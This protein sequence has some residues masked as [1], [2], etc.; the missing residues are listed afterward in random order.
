VAISPVV[1]ATSITPSG[2]P[3][4]SGTSGGSVAVAYPAVSAGQVLLLCA[5]NGAPAANSTPGGWTL[6]DHVD[7]ASGDTAAALYWKLAVGNESG[8]VTVTHTAGSPTD[9]PIGAIVAL[10]G[11]STGSTPIFSHGSSSNSSASTTSPAPPTLSPVPGATD[12]VLRFYCASGQGT[13]SMVSMGTVGGTWT[14]NLR[15]YTTNASIYDCGMTVGSKIGGTDSQT[16]TC[17]NSSGWVILAVSVAGYS[18]D[19]FLPFFM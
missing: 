17:G 15:Q 5:V 13:G 3:G 4:V 12:L 1:A 10:S 6:L 14:T 19:G 2:G 9:V 8:N 18:T 16:I 11:C 7:S